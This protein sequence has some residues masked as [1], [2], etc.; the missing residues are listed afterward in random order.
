M[1]SHGSRPRL[2]TLILRAPRAFVS[3]HQRVVDHRAGGVGVVDAEHRD[4]LGRGREHV[5]QV[6]DGAGG[7]AG[8]ARDGAVVL[9]GPADLDQVLLRAGLLDV[10]ELVEGPERPPVPGDGLGAER[11]LLPQVRMVQAAARLALQA[12]DLA[13]LVLVVGQQAGEVAVGERLVLLLLDQRPDGVEQVALREAQP[14]VLARAGDDAR[15]VLD[16]PAS[17]SDSFGSGAGCACAPCACARAPGRGSP[18]GA[19]WPSRR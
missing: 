12:G 18:T 8:D 16:A 3:L 6:F 9:L 14:S 4:R 10:D 2:T 1:P 7:E 5:E 13:V 19:A 11:D 15:Q 17:L